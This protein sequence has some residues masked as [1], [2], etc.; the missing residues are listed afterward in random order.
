MLE[1]AFRIDFL[2]GRL[3][4]DTLEDYF[5]RLAEFL[6][7]SVLTRGRRGWYREYVTDQDRI[8]SVRGRIDAAHLR[9]WE[10]GLPA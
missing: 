9:P 8:P 10:V 7:Q 5:E 6:A 4:C 3:T 2:D 1:Y